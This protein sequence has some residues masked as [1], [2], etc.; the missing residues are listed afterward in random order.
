MSHIPHSLS[1]G[2]LHALAFPDRIAKRRSGADNRYQLS[3]GRGVVLP[4][5]DPLVRHDYLVVAALDAGKRD[6]RAYLAAPITVDEIRQAQGGYIGRDSRIEWDQSTQSVM[7]REEERLGAIVL[8]T[9]PL[10]RMDTDLT[11]KAMIAGIR[12]AGLAILPWSDD[13]LQWRERVVS[14]RLWL[15]DET[16]PDLSDSVLTETLD[17]WLAPWLNGMM[18]FEHLK[19]LDLVGIL[20]NLLSWEQQQKLEKLAPVHITMPSGN[21][22]TASLHGR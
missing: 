3:S 2:G 16:W 1:I 8:S 7:A 11:C 19:Q 9:K 12:Q 20:K 21:R 17:E 14:L 13:L 22:Q 6:G 15:L 18:R 10:T 5:G 4:E